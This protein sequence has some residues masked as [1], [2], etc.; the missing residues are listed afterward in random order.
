M[1]QRRCQETMQYL[2]DDPCL[3]GVVQATMQAAAQQGVAPATS[4]TSTP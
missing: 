3:Q 1:Q 4:A 2:D